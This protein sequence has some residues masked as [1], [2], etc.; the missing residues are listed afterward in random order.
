M[1]PDTPSSEAWLQF[2]R[3]LEAEH[4]ER[5]N[6]IDRDLDLLCG[7]VGLLSVFALLSLVVFAAWLLWGSR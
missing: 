7:V 6:Q 2:Q 5:A 4:R 1:K 3:R